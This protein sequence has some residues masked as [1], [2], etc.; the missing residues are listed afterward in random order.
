MGL[1]SNAGRKEAQRDLCSDPNPQWWP[2]ATLELSHL[3][4]K[5]QG[6]QRARTLTTPRPRAW[7][8]PLGV[9]PVPTA[10]AAAIGRCVFSIII[11]HQP[12]SPFSQEHLAP[13]PSAKP[14]SWHSLKVRCLLNGHPYRPV[15][16]P[17]PAGLQVGIARG[18]FQGS[19]PNCARLTLSPL[20]NGAITQPSSGWG[21]GLALP[22][23]PC[24]ALDPSGQPHQA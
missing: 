17:L 7:L 6:H 22:W 4:C 3:L 16:P 15:C 23:T 11:S 12:G 13:D 10:L 1:G 14:C 8:G 5:G 24:W 21:S 9:P 2:R 19:L 18:S 20:K